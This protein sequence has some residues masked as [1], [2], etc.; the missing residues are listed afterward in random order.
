MTRKSVLEDVLSEH[1]TN[2][3]SKALSLFISIQG[4][5]WDLSKL[6]K[7]RIDTVESKSNYLPVI[8]WLFQMDIQTLKNVLTPRISVK[9]YNINRLSLSRYQNEITIFLDLK[10]WFINPVI[11]II[12]RFYQGCQTAYLIIEIPI[13]NIN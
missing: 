9:Q 1:F 6:F 5:H 4:N 3:S 11:E 7:C 12:D 10:T 2:L 13:L 8:S